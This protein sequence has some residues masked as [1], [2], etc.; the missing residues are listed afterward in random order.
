MLDPDGAVDIIAARRT[1][2]VRGMYGAFESV[3]GVFRQIG[4]DER[5]HKED[6]LAQM[7][8]DRFQ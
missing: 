6:S 4:H 2:T 3:A 8:E 5:V 1:S 7:K